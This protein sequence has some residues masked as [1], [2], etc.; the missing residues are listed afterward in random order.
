MKKRSIIALFAAAMLGLSGCSDPAGSTAGSSQSAADKKPGTEMPTVKE[1]GKE[2]RLE[3]PKSNPPK[4]LQKTVIAEGEGRVIEENDFV[5]A[6]YVGQVWGNKKPFD[7]SFTRGEGTGFSLQQVIAGWTKG[8]AGLKPGAKVILSI[9]SEMGYGP[10]GGNAQAGIGKDDTIAFYV[11]ILAAYG[12]NQAGDP[13]AKVETDVASLPVE[14]TGELGKPITVKVKDGVAS[15]TEVSTTVIARG[16]GPEIGGEGSNFYIQYAMSLVN[17]SKAE[18]SYGESGPIRSTIGR[19]SI[20][21]GLKGVPVGS[22]VLIMAPAKG[23]DANQPG[24]AVV[25]DV[26]G[27][28]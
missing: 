3:F 21:D 19:G 27:V 26:L 7:S 8:L 11:E 14:I 5:V 9:P 23:Q 12:V 6:N 10:Q 16:S 17:N 4:G 24:Y 15:P 2:T 1:A 25:V 13:N 20:F 22:R 18:K 28:D